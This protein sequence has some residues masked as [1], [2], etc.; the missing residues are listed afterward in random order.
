MLPLWPSFWLEEPSLPKKLRCPLMAEAEVSVRSHSEE[1]WGNSP[2]PLLR[3]KSPYTRE[4]VGH[5]HSSI[6]ACTVARTVE[7]AHGYMNMVLTGAVRVCES[8]G[9]GGGWKPPHSASPPP[10][11]VFAWLVSQG[12]LAR[13][14]IVCCVSGKRITSSGGQVGIDGVQNL[15]TALE[16]PGAQELTQITLLFLSCNSITTSQQGH[17]PLLALDPGSFQFPLVS[18]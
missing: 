17:Q 11:N 6:Q 2:L 13:S 3:N 15:T 7:Q 12:L 18:A 16:A 10:K 4:G 1:C 14:R 5:A 8:V 9:G